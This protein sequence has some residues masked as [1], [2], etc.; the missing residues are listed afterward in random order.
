MA[1]DRIDNLFAGESWSAVYTAFTNISLKAYDFDNIREALLSYI[2]QTYPDKFNDYIAS[3]EFIAV[4]DLVAYLGHSLSFRMDLNSRENFLDTAERRSSILRLAKNLGYQKKRPINS[5][6]FMKITS[7]STNQ[8]V[9]DSDGKSLQ[10]KKILWNDS[11]NENWYDNFVTVLNAALQ[12]NTKTNSPA[13]S[14]TV[15]N[16]ENYI[17]YVNENT[18]SKTVMYSFTGND[19]GETR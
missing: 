8:K 12:Y 1:Q 10:S 7:V 19:D 4:L 13:A 14:L 6:G 15:G 5:R 17:H 2:A 16:V 9:Y 18:T 3:S 11:N